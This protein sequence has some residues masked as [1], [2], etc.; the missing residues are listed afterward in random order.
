MSND[1][2]DKT[3]IASSE[4]TSPV[5][6]LGDDNHVI[7][8]KGFSGPVPPPDMLHEYENVLPGAAE[9]I[10]ILAEKNQSASEKITYGV[11][12]NDKEKIRYSFIV[13][14]V[15]LIVPFA[16]AA[17]SMYLGQ[18]PFLS[19]GLGIIGAIILILLPKIGARPEVDSSTE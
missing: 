4:E 11:I 9:R 12:S 19:G 14:I 13:S 16:P 17:I 3:P 5:T 15:S 8:T 7:T 1:K 2:D 6:K 18:N 10:F